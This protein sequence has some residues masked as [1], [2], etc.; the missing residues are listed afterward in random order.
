M[1]KILAVF[2][3]LV[4][5]ALPLSAFAADY[6]WNTFFDVQNVDE[7]NGTFD[8]VCYYQSTA[9]YTRSLSI[10]ITIPL[11]VADAYYA[12]YQMT[13]A[14]LDSYGVSISEL[15]YLTLNRD[16]FPE[17]VE[18]QVELPNGLVVTSKNSA[19]SAPEEIQ[20]VRVNRND[21]SEL[22]V[23]V[24]YTTPATA[25]FYKSGYPLGT[26][27]VEAFR[28]SMKGDCTKVLDSI[29]V[30]T[31][32]TLSFGGDEGDISSL[33]L[34]LDTAVVT[35]DPTVYED[36]D[37]ALIFV[38]SSTRKVT[39]G[40]IALKI[41]GYTLIELPA[42]VFEDNPNVFGISVKGIEESGISYKAISGGI[43]GQTVT[44]E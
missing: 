4:I 10:V 9:P 36:E 20:W 5:M 39:D 42:G 31:V 7:A 13:R 29:S 32:N 15:S 38:G 2:T 18:T 43:S 44:V 26:E 11:S 40:K 22:L 30:D 41:P 19:F 3:A 37:G 25:Y 21:S 24:T 16:S 1:K 34:N 23:T 28:V 27:P 6:T 14:E 17:S 8:L 12:P 35:T 33:P